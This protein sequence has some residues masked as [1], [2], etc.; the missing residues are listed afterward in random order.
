[1]RGRE[2]LS[3][4]RQEEEMGVVY[5]LFHTP[6]KRAWEE[7]ERKG[8]KRKR[9]NKSLTCELYSKIHT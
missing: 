1:M 7:R 2:T 4:W 8:G 5:F 6:P 3:S 9:K